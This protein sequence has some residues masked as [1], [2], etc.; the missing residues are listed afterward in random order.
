MA[1]LTN[2]KPALLLKDLI[3]EAALTTLRHLV[4]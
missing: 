4:Q 1:L 3:S 2:L